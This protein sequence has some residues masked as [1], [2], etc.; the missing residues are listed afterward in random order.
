MKGRIDQAK[1]KVKKFAGKV[2]GNK[3]L[4]VKGKLQ[5]AG[6]KIQACFGDTRKR[7]R[8]SD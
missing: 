1:G 4:E 7:H 3:D 8:K 5:S 2:T 6:G